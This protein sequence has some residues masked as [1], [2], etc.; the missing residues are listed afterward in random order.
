MGKQTINVSSPND[1]LGDSLR[2]SQV[3]ANSNFTELYNNKVDKVGGKGLSDNNFTLADKVK[4]DLIDAGAEVNVQSD[5][6]QSD[7]T[8]DSF[9]K[10]KSGF[11]ASLPD[12][13]SR[14]EVEDANYTVVSNDSMLI[15]FT[16]LTADRVV[17]LPLSSNKNQK[18]FVI[19]ESGNCN[20]SAK[21]TLIASGFESING[22]T[23]FEISSAFG[24]TSLESNGSGEWFII[25]GASSTVPTT[26][27]STTLNIN[28]VS[29]DLSANREWRTAQADTG[30][31]TFSGLATNSSTTINI[32]A[33]TGYVVDNETTPSVPVSAYV[34]YAG[35]TNVTVTTIGSGIGTYVMLSSVGVISFQNT[36]PTPAE[37]KAKIWLGKVAHPSGSITAVINEPDYITS[38]MG[39]A[40][41]ICQ[42]FGF[43]NNGVYPT[44][45]GA[46]LNLNIVGG[47]ITG[48]GI[49]FVSNRANPN[50]LTIASGSSISF[51]PRTQTGAGGGGVTSIISGSY[52]VGGVV[53]AVG[54]GSGS[55]TIQY[56]Y[57]VPGQGYIVT[58]GQTVYATLD[59]A[60][61]AVG[62]ESPVIF[63]NLVGNAILIGALAVNKNA[64]ALNNTTQAQFYLASKLGQLIAVGGG[65]AM[66]LDAVPTDGSTNAVESNG[67]FDALAA[68]QASLG[69]TPLRPSNNL[70]DVTDPK[71]SR[72]WLFI[73]NSITTGDNDYGN[74]FYKN[75]IL[76]TALTAVRTHTLLDL[77]GD[78]YVLNIGECTNI[79][80]MIGGISATNYISVVPYSGQT[81]NGSSTPILL[82]ERFGMFSFKRTSATNWTYDEVSR[83]SAP[84]ILRNKNIVPRVQTD[85][86]ASAL[87]LNLDNADNLE[88]LSLTGNITFANPT[89]TPYNMKGY[90]FK[91]KDN[92]TPRSILW[93]S[94]FIANPLTVLP[95]TTVANQLHISAFRY[96]SATGK[97]INEYN[98]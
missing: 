98:V 70:S 43:I 46:N 81:I 80:D 42:A 59:L 87:T 6:M 18:I 10:G 34:S 71:T 97:L 67:V 74:H 83:A 11:I 26:D 65:A 19:D 30:V 94:N 60:K 36:F 12:G 50:I 92:G 57:T 48:D 37:R 49:N 88:C 85:T 66:V 32:G 33:A 79:V 3:K 35:A 51:M 69:Y 16:S 68:K 28:G 61:S 82:K 21:I 23:Y 89:G 75:I 73:E 77:V 17:F 78:T 52:D 2:A 31:L 4:L 63:P 15:A 39:L 86:Y 13:Y 64:T 53:T 76:T 84:Q 22:V 58:Y 20:P 95:S 8:Q 29:Q 55:S 54:G 5:L 24:F 7:D 72:G 90:I 41:D 56:I 45:N 14:I 25:S 96:D 62:K 1:G 91:Y 44:F 47:T 27:P 40:R 93:G 38:P 9:V